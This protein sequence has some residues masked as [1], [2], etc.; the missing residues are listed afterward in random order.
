MVQQRTVL[1]A[2][3]TT[4]DNLN[5]QAFEEFVKNQL[6]NKYAMRVLD[7]MRSVGTV[8]TLCMC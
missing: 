2:T 7:P 1:M 3:P 6:K 4:P 8:Q 5:R